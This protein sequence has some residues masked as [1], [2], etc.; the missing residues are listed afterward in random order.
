MKKMFSLLTLMSFSFGTMSK[1]I[2]ASA[3][4]S[5]LIPP[6]I[7]AETNLDLSYKNGDNYNDNKGDVVFND[8]GLKSDGWRLWHTFNIGFIN[9]ITYKKIMFL[10]TNADFYTKISWGN[11]EYYGD[12]LNKYNAC[13]NDNKV[14]NKIINAKVLNPNLDVPRFVRNESRFFVQSLEIRY[15]RAYLSA[16][17]LFALTWYYDNNNYYIQVFT[18]Y[19]VKVWHSWIYGGTWMGIGTGIRLYND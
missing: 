12:K 4:E 14:S 6:V 7:K 9:P 19:W 5:Q 11:D 18:Y 16:T 17:Q 15:I 13:Y 3:L 2:A 10:G 8:W 1:I